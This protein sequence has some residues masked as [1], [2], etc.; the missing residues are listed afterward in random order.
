MI[1]KSKSILISILKQAMENKTRTIMPEIKTDLVRSPKNGDSFISH[2]NKLMPS[3]EFDNNPITNEIN[4][5]LLANLNDD[6]ET[7]NPKNTNEKLAKLLS[8]KRYIDPNGLVENFTKLIDQF[9]TEITDPKIKEAILKKIAINEGD[10]SNIGWIFAKL[11]KLTTLVDLDKS[12]SN[13]SY[14]LNGKNYKV[15]KYLQKDL[16]SNKLFD[17]LKQTPIGQSPKTYEAKLLKNEI[18]LDALKSYL[19]EN[20]KAEPELTNYLYEK[21]YLPRLSLDVKLF[22]RKISNEFNTKLFVENETNLTAC[23]VIYDELA[24]SKTVSNGKFIAPPVIN[25]SRYEPYFFE[26]T[27]A[28]GYADDYASPIHLAGDEHTNILF[29]L[30]HELTHINDSYFEHES[31]IINGVDIDSII[32]RGHK[33]ENGERG[34]VIWNLCKYKDEFFNA[35]I[36]PYLMRYA[37]TDAREFKAIAA[38]GDCSKYSPEF[39]KLLLKIG[40]PEYVFELKPFNKSYTDNA[41]YIAFIKQIH[42]ELK[43]MVDVIR[44]IRNNTE[45]I[46]ESRKIPKTLLD[47]YITTQ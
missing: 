19:M 44:H 41:D 20:S 12:L 17:E 11:L 36:T 37:Y 43:T 47:A 33:K 16:N 8:N 46:E 26:N 18:E 6:K 13:R 34:D 24:E 3:E 30:R 23:S 7:L 28:K 29:G 38:E 9:K 21:Y 1:E 40:L 39:K 2:P 4:R 42:P 31:G 27:E 35:G 25:L 45:K 14:S 32:V 22:C 10:D 15:V 5:L